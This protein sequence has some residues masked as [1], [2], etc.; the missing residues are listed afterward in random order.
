MRRSEFL[1]H[2]HWPDLYRS[3]PAPVYHRAWWGRANAR[4]CLRVSS[5][6]RRLTPHQ[7]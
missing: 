5:R 1:H 6:P 4:V 7:P 2:S 3:S